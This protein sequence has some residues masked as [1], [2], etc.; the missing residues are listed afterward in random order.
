MRQLYA[1]T[2]LTPVALIFASSHVQAETVVSTARTTAIATSSANAG[3]A[4][5]IRISTA[6]SVK[7]A[8]GIAVTLDSANTVVNEGAIQITGANDAVGIQAAA[9]ITGTITNTGSISIDENFTPT[10][11]DNDGDKDGPFAQGARRFGIRTVGTFAGNILNSGTISVEGNNSAG[12]ALGGTLTGSLTHGGS[13][14][15]V[16]DNSYGIQAGAISGNAK[17][18]GNVAVQGANSVAVALQG[19]IGGALVIQS[20]ISSTGYRSATPPT[21][22]SKLDADDLLQGGS[23]L[24]VAGSVGG[25]ILFD[26]PPR[27]TDP[28]NKDEDNDGIE[29]AKEGSAV[30]AT[31]GAAA[32]VQIGSAT[33]NTLIGPIAGASAGGNGIVINGSILGDG[34][35]K[36]VQ[37]NGLVIGGLGGN[38]S[39]AG[40]MTVNGSVAASSNGA[41]ATAVRLGSGATVPTIKN[42]GSITATG[43]SA[44]TTLVRAVVVD[45]GASLSSITNSGRIVATAA[46][47]GSAVAI[48]DNSGTLSL[49]TNS[50]AISATSA[51]PAVNKAVAIDLSANGSG[52]T[53]RQ[54]L[55][56]ANVAAPTIAG[57]ILFGTGNDLLDIADGSMNGATR[58]GA[59]DNRLA[60]AGD[61]TYGGDVTF[62]SGNDIVTLAGTTALTGNVDFG[63][64]TDSLSLTGTAKFKGAIAGSAGLALSVNGG[65]LAVVNK[66]PV[67]LSSIDVSGQGAIGVNIDAKAGTFTQYQVSGAASFA[68]G[69]KVLVSLANVSQSEGQYLIVKAGALT[70]G[71]NI[72]ANSLT[73]P[74][75]FKSS[76]VAS[77]ALGEVKLNIQRKSATELGLNG[78]QSR[79]YDA[80]FKALDN[81]VQVAGSFLNIADGASFR[82]ALQQMLPDHAGG[83]FETVTQASRATA[84]FLSDPRAPFSDQGGWGFWLQQVAWG[85][86][87]GLGNTASY[88]ITGWGASGGVEAKTGSL[89][90]FGLS[91]AYLAGSDGDGSNSNEVNTN[92]YELAAYWRANWGKLH[93]HARGS[94][95]LIGL[96]GSRFFSASNAGQTV[97]RRATSSWDGRLIG[98]SAGLAYELSLTRRFSL[99][100]S[101]SIDYY[102]L[103][104]DGYTEKGGGAALN[105]IVSDRTSDEMAV[106]GSI[107]AGM[108]FGSKDPNSTWF[109]AEIE[110]GRRQLIGGQIGSTTAHFTNGQN[111]VLLPEARTDGWVGGLRMTGGTSGFMLGG[112]FN[113][114]QQQGRAAV[115]FRVTLAIGL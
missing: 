17:I 42:V 23:A 96:K 98:A 29:D 103:K 22:V 90:N 112:E 95:A 80:V 67:A 89:G 30:V 12:I 63:G 48:F 8:S 106:N 5:N 79:A 94:A 41:N 73:V 64:G 109:R 108:D 77:D 72:V 6:G 76:I 36:D 58:F 56:G 50:G 93:A 61:A 66:G 113:A 35:Y 20:A 70:G 7:P 114:E 91:L 16:G 49:V 86:S 104:E 11:T 18:M 57:N 47:D 39:V 111:F 88:D 26:V 55:V 102:H 78:S 85:T 81:D 34:A 110:G 107:I 28:A 100:P 69:S 53:V 101:A 38:V 25:G 9:G 62:G 99:R 71:S 15:V 87:K 19:D 27:D 68:A 14:T 31:K 4:D 46:V 54:T 75:L 51:N 59:G 83:A 10:D 43:G 37:G 44:A 32:A 2:C 52:A 21:D 40:G 13:I 105:L 92:Q 115:A 24:V 3:S 84:R 33:L 82:K 97:E 65:T 45:A 74:F 60:L 1:C